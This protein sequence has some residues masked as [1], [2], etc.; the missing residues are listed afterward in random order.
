M[1]ADKSG[2]LILAEEDYAQEVRQD[3]SKVDS[4]L[5]ED[6]GESEPISIFSMQRYNRIHPRAYEP[7]LRDL[8]H[9]VHDIPAWLKRFCSATCRACACY[10]NKNAVRC[11]L[12]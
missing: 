1:G 10:T 3:D 2:D 5:D 11:S 12:C 9:M 6:D 7:T 4:L 8:T